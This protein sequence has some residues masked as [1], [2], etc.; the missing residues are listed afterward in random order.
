MAVIFS[1]VAGGVTECDAA[2]PV[3]V[4]LSKKEDA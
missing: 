1:A 3:A 4:L 2:A